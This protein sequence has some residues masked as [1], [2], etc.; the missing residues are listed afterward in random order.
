MRKEI[1]NWWEQAQRDYVKAEV[2]FHAKQYDGVAFYA[3]QTVEKV[4]KALFLQE[5]DD[6]K[7]VHDL[8]Y[9]STKLGA[10]QKIKEICSV[11]TQVYVETRY[12]DASTVIPAEKFSKADAET[13]LENAREV[14]EWVRKKLLSN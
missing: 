14:T 1:H 7:K 6:I 4:L 12:P 5:F 8:S 11:L 2:L 3:Q 10:P 9:L 13:F